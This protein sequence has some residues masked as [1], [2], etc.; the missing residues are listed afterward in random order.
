MGHAILTKQEDKNPK[1]PSCFNNVCIPPTFAMYVYWNTPL[2]L[3]NIGLSV[4]LSMYF[5][6]NIL[7]PYWNNVQIPVILFMNFY[8]NIPHPC[9]D[10]VRI[11]VI[12]SMYFCWKILYPCLD[13]VWIAVRLH[14]RQLWLIRVCLTVF[15]TFRIIP[16]QYKTQ[17]FLS[18]VCM[19][20]LNAQ[21]TLPGSS[22]GVDWRFLVKASSHQMEKIRNYN[23]SATNL[24][25]K[26]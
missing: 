7:H 22:N 8:W 24:F 3:D 6:W 19:Y 18:F 11:P 1:I 9:L 16:I 23:L 13:N 2:C 12:L 15:Q 14:Q 21:G 10:N 26:W 17:G 20:V 25:F 4:T 5:H